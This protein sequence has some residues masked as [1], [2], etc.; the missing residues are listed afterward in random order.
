VTNTTRKLLL[1]TCIIFQACIIGAQSLLQYTRLTASDG[2]SSNSVQCILQDRT[3][4]FW[5]GT[6]NG[7]NRYDG[8]R[9]IQYSVLSRPGLTNGVITSLMQDTSG[10][11][12]IG[13]EHG[14]NILDPSSNSVRR[15]VHDDKN[16]GSLP[17]GPIRGL[18]QLNDGTILL[19]SDRWIA[20]AN[21]SFQFTLLRVDPQLT[22]SN[23]VM[24]GITEGVNHEIWISYLDSGSA[25]T[26]R[27]I[28]KGR[29]DSISAPL[30]YTRDYSRIFTDS[31][32]INYS[33]SSEGVNRFNTSTLQFVPLIKSGPG[34]KS[35]NLHVHTCFA[36]DADGNIWQGSERVNLLKYDTKLRMAIDY[37]W[38][39]TSSNATMTNVLYKDNSNNIWLG[40]DNGIIKISSRVSFFS[41]LPFEIN[42]EELENIRCR[43]IIADRDNNVYAG[44]ENYGLIRRPL[45]G[46][47]AQPL[48][49]FGNYPISRLPDINNQIHVPLTGRF[50]IGYMY[51]LWYDNKNAIWIAG[52]S[53]ARYDLQKAV[54]DVF[55]T[56][57]SEQLRRESITQFSLCFG[58]SL[59]WTG[60]QYNVFT[61][62]P[63]TR[64]MK[65]FEDNFG[66]QPFHGTPTW[67]IANYGGFIWAGTYKGLYRI[68][69]KSH[70]VFK[71]AAHPVLDNGIND[72]LIAK[73][74]SFWI[75]TAG[76][77]IVNYNT[78]TGKC[79]QYSTEQGLSNNTVCGI[80]EDD[81]NDLWISTYAGLS[82]FN[83][84]S[85][86]FTNYYVKDGLT[87][88][89]FNRKAFSKLPDGRMIFGGLKGYII[90]NPKDAFKNEKPMNLLLTHFSKTNQDGEVEETIFGANELK[91]VVIYP[92][93][94]FFS[95][96]FTLTDMYDPTGNNYDYQLRGL[97]NKWHSAGND[98]VISF[99]SL[100]AGKYTLTIKGR[101]NK[102]S[103]AQNEIVIPI[104]VKQVFYKTGWFILLM[105]LLA[106][107][108]VYLIFLYRIRQIKKWQLLRT[109]IASDLHDEVGGSL[110]RITMLT[111]AMKREGLHDQTEEQLKVISGIS[112]GAISTM[113]DVIWS[114]DARNDTLTG[115]VDHIHEHTHQMLVPARIEFEFNDNG[116]KGNDKMDM[117]FRQHIYL[118]FKEAI[119]NIVKHSGATLVRISI[120]RDGGI[121]SMRIQDNGRGITNGRRS[122]G[123][124]ME[125]MKMRAAKMKAK[126]EIITDNGTTILLI[127][128]E[129]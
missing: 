121:F 115:L 31:S 97:D 118:I 94:T 13:T 62:N 52:Y 41:Y 96:G 109:R 103:S 1:L 122:S 67:S 73:D 66:N 21:I 53:I 72:I 125:N 104:T 30:F 124:G 123:Q 37:K 7:L 106:A 105:V 89:E 17:A 74:C 88:D 25:L 78:A 26:N 61:F 43:R 2:L 69:P 4:I 65:P 64:K 93:D 57:D 111:D 100:P 75:S 36:I 40:T 10:Y 82:Y 102:G 19:M 83:R 47:A 46:G 114:I 107:G 15:F 117:D 42:G 84:K 77:G 99:T 3:G 9:F 80:L 20:K 127:V 81:N 32:H 48:S 70:E 5:I 71:P 23:M 59:F 49:T 55:L 18:Q 27:I 68:N 90:F 98:G 87:S 119:N 60:G 110:V 95:F 126:L 128:P 33:I 28:E 50:D 58:D 54:M 34:D 120:S 63:A 56:E 116:L 108:I 112:R 11:I 16:Q 45:G 51:D 85:G 8:S 92:D 91:E 29:P 101:I 79:T 38:L 44:T 113:K 22:R 35:P 76:G 86:Q 39:L 12:W 14:L 6:N 24:T 129:K